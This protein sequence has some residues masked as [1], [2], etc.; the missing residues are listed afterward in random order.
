MGLS[1]GKLTWNGEVCV[2]YLSH[3]LQGTCRIS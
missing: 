2:M 1:D 3:E